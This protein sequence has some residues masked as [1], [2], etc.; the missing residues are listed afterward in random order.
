MLT[1]FQV[2]KVSWQHKIRLVSGACI[3]AFV[4]SVSLLT[5]CI[6]VDKPED[7]SPSIEISD[8]SIRIKEIE[9]RIDPPMAKRPFLS[10]EAAEKAL[11]PP[12]DNHLAGVGVRD[13]G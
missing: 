9:L 8:G 3:M 7:Q 5:R 10:L 12:K 1:I 4:V 13:Y 2:K 11:G 6:A